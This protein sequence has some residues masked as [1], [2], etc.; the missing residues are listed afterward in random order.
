MHIIGVSS[1]SCSWGGNGGAGGA[2]D[3]LARL[4]APSLSAQLKQPVYVEN[5]PGANGQIG[6]AFVRNAPADG[7]VIMVTTEHPVVILPAMTE[8]APYAG[9]DFVILGKI[10]NLQWA[11]STGRDPAIQSLDDFVTIFLKIKADLVDDV[12]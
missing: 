11:L 9:E 7:S 10:A 3:V 5:R 8:S 1:S 6:A 12:I 4:L 2:T